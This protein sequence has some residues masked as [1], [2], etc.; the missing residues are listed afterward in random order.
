MIQLIRNWYDKLLLE[1]VGVFPPASQRW[2]L[3]RSYGVRQVAHIL[4]RFALLYK[5]ELSGKTERGSQILQNL[6]FL[7]EDNP[8]SSNRHWH[9][10]DRETFE[11]W[12]GDLETPRLP[13]FAIYKPTLRVR[14][15]RWLPW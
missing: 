2:L 1:Y 12:F 13:E 10:H 7:K 5:E 6:G 11:Q 15:R 4:N 3:R 9:L 14:V 8:A